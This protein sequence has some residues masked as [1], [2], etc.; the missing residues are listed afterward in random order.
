MADDIDFSISQ[1][2]GA[3]RLMCSASPDYVTDGNGDV[4][5]IFSDVPA[6]FFNVAIPTGREI[7]HDKLQQMARDATKW[8]AGRSVPWM[9]LVTHEA[10]APG[11]DAS[12]AL[13]AAGLTPMLPMT[14][15][16][17]QRIA[18]AARAADGLALEVPRD[19]DGCSAILDVNAAAYDVPLDVCKP[20]YG[21]PAFWTGHS[22]SLGRVNGEPVSS[23]AVFMV[24]GYRY[25]A[26]VATMPDRQRRGYAEAAMRYA[27]DTAASAYGDTPTTLHAT[28]AG[29][30]IYARM[31][32]E[33]IA[34]HTAF[35][36][37]R[38]LGEGH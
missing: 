16:R 14:G 10:L 26:L 36:E 6:P 17:A 1:F 18:P 32:Y 30:P 9:F 5:Y 2:S 15:M 3:W 27:L 38:F 19:A 8:A 12:S 31:G 11:V 37:T 25:V 28:D 33:P 7:S 34:T 23:A 22:P 21:Q 20:T 13:D 24:D 29:R 4:E 35:I